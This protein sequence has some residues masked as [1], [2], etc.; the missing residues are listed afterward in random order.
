MTQTDTSQ[1]QSTLS[2]ASLLSS[3]LANTLFKVPATSAVAS[4]VTT[5]FTTAIFRLQQNQAL[6]PK[7][8]RSNMLLSL[9]FFMRGLRAQMIS[10]QQRGAVNITAKNTTTPDQMTEETTRSFFMHPVFLSF[11]FSQLDI[12]VSQVYGNKA[13]LEATG[14]IT[15][16]NFGMSMHNAKQ[17]FAMA[18]PYRSAAN[19]IHFNALCLYADPLARQF[20]FLPPTAASFIG[21]ATAGA[22]ATVVAFPLS[23]AMED[24]VAKTTLSA[25][26]QLQR[27]KALEYLK[28]KMS[29]L[30]DRGFITS[31][32]EFAIHTK[33]QLP[34]RACYNATIFA[35]VLG[36][37][38]L[39]GEKPLERLTALQY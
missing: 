13:K 10:G 1:A 18:Y 17:L 16:A 25:E 33:V 5:P 7:E 4:V 15:K 36:M 3:S 27:V 37:N 23:Y 12:V 6:F 22:I 24:T 21:G 26:G 28:P 32:V 38:E 2:L 34:L 11:A 20:N 8:L 14:L 19:F 29:Y 30:K 9:P 39:L 31:L 35:C